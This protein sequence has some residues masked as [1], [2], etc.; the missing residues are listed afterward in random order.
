MK[1]L[2]GGTLDQIQGGSWLGDFGGGA[3]C[4]FAIGM[5]IVSGGVLWPV[6]IFGCM[7]AL[8]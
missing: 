4:G 5:A 8:G 2:N 3:A 1:D 7:W 6:A